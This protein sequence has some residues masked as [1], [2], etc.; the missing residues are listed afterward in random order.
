MTT[1]RRPGLFA[2]AAIFAV[3]AL[4]SAQSEH[5]AAVAQQHNQTDVDFLQERARLN[6]AE[7]RI[8]A[9]SQRLASLEQGA[10][11]SARPS[12]ARDVAPRRTAGPAPR[13]RDSTAVRT[14]EDGGVAQ[15]GSRI[16]TTLRHRDRAISATDLDVLKNELESLQQ[17]ARS[18][19]E[20]LNR[21]DFGA[22]LR[23]LERDIT[24]LE[25]DISSFD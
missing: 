22:G 21:P 18:V 6:A 11:L 24:D 9:L 8:D 4:H 16:P 20:R 1:R 10:T 14:H 12:S 25:T 2:A 15:T 7:R 13:S 17:T 19:G 3:A 5:S 23:A